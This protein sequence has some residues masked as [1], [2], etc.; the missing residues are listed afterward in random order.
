MCEVAILPHT[1][2]AAGMPIS[3]RIAGDQLCDLVGIKTCQQKVY[4]H[5]D[6]FKGI[7]PPVRLAIG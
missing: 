1:H 6:L 5:Q 4:G 3:H 2:L 7:C